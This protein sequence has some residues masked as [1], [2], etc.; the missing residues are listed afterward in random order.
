MDERVLERMIARSGSA[1]K[2]SSALV[3]AS[4]GVFLASIFWIVLRLLLGGIGGVFR[5]PLFFLTSSFSLLPLALVI[6]P[7]ASWCLS[8]RS[9]TATLPLNEVVYHRWKQAVG[10][11]LYALFI[12]VVEL[13]LGIAVALWC[14]L[15][16]IPL[17]GAAVYLFFSWVPAIITLIM[18][19]LLV[20]HVFVLVA[21]AASL[22]QSPSIDQ[23]QMWAELPGILRQEWS[24]RVKCVFVGA[25]PS[26]IL[27][28][29]S[30]TWIMKGLPQTLEFCSSIFRMAAFSAIEAPLFLFLIHMAV[31]ADRYIHWLSSRRVE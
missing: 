3:L 11:F 12:A 19:I 17:F 27:Y 20:L 30:S 25:L 5:A 4:G 6:V 8:A 31:E 24:L 7:I 26:I 13:L 29:A 15:E 28:F 14:G 22:A 21:A 23:K 10:F 9:G 1:M 16:A 2:G 18:G